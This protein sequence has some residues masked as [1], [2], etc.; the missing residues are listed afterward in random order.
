MSEFVD[1]AKVLL[2]LIDDLQ[3]ELLE[4]IEELTMAHFQAFAGVSYVPSEL[5]FVIIDTMVKR[6]NRVGSE[7]MTSQTVDGLAQVFNVEDFKEYQSA[8]DS[9]LYKKRRSG[10]M[11][12]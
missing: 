8:I 2:N 11:F 4:V 5:N 3:D 12:L 9:V 7:G 6:F 10:V 1:K